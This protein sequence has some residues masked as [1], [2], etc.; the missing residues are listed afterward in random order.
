MKSFLPYPMAVLALGLSP[1][2]PP[3][4]I[5]LPRASAAP[6]SGGQRV[7]RDT[8]TTADTTLATPRLTS[9]GLARL[10]TLA[11]LLHH[12]PTAVQDSARTIEADL[13]PDLHVP[14]IPPSKT[15]FG[16]QVPT[17]AVVDWG[18]AAHHFPVVA[19]AFTNAHL[20]PR[21]YLGL[22]LAVQS[23]ELAI[24]L[25]I[26]SSNASRLADI[27]KPLVSDT[28]TVAEKNIEFAHRHQALMATIDHD[29]ASDTIPNPGGLSPSTD[30][31][32]P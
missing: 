15:T 19:A 28:T 14:E 21:D 24:D 22:Q 25:M 13:I 26:D 27:T 12:L 10:H 5:G 2:A 23:A 31:L 1:Q 29:F 11:G 30:S 16:G 6:I 3:S 8:G 32:T 20:P 17:I 18:T 4:G 9:E 7:G